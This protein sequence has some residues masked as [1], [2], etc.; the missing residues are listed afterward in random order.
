[1]NKRLD[2]IYISGSLT[3]LQG[4]IKKTYEQIEKICSRFY[5]DIYVPH[6]KGS[7]PI[8]NPNV[9]PAVVWKNNHQEVA[10]SDLLIAY[11]GQP[12]LGVG[13][14]LEIARITASDIIIWWFKGEKVSR[15]VLGNPAIK[16]QIEAD[17]E[18]DLLNKLE[19]ILNY[20]KN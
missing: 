17:N 20:Y 16:N 1:M 19:N 14:E 12:S 8:L 9:A 10:A 18:N 6:L 13:A 3:H 4:N 2:K 15:M 7:D 5:S 11:V